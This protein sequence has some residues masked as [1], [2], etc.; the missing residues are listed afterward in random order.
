MINPI[1]IG[2]SIELKL[3]KPLKFLFNVAANLGIGG[4]QINQVG[5]GI[6]FEKIIHTDK[7]PFAIYLSPLVGVLIEKIPIP[8]LQTFT[9]AQYEWM[10]IKAEP[11]QLVF[12]KA[13]PLLTF[14]LGCSYEITRKNHLN[15]EIQ[16]NYASKAANNLSIS[17]PTSSIPLSQNRILTSSISNHPL[18]NL[19]FSIKLF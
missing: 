16:Y 19:T 17:D 11:I 13:I 7:R 1:L 8:G 9:A 12:S 10:H 5:L 15:F 2:F 18:N 4:R 6:K 14:V 3:G